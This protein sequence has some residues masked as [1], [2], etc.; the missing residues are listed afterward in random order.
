MALLD[1]VPATHGLATRVEHVILEEI[2]K[3]A[4]ATVRAVPDLCIVAL[5]YF[6]TRLCWEILD[7]Y[8]RSVTA[9]EVKSGMFDEITAET[10][11]RLASIGIWIVAIIMA[12]PYIPG[13][14]SPA[15]RGVSVLAGLMLSLGSANLVGQ[16]ASGLTLI[17]GRALKPGE[18]IA[19]GETEGVVEQIGLF[20]CMIRTPRGEVVVLP[21]AALAGGLKNFSRQASRL[22]LTTEVT[23]GYDAPW[24][25]V[26]DLLLAAAQETTGIRSEPVPSVRQVALE[27]FYVRYEVQFTP[28]DPADRIPLLSRLHAAIQDRF[29]EAGV[30]IMSPSYRA[31][32]TA[33]KIPPGPYRDTPGK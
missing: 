14:E 22:R 11:R 20:A 24:R 12:Y 31:D 5:I 1:L 26:R 28:D 18:Y 3:L 10:T 9:G 6:A 15:F 16:F 7:H 13:S 4:L 23:I 19:C 32:P 17:Y 2:G 33:P 8:F 27:D 30:Q 21:H 29:H 25:Q